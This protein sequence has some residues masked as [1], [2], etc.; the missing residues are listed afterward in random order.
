MAAF[1]I[2][3]PATRSCPL[4]FLSGN[5]WDSPEKFTVELQN[6][7]QKPIRRLI[8][9]S[10]YFLGPQYLHRP[11]TD[12]NWS[13]SQPL[14]PGQQQVLEKKAY[15]TPTSKQILGWVLFPSIINYEDGT[16]WKPE[17][18]GE[19]F[20]IFWRDREHPNLTVLPPLQVDLNED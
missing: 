3:Q 5:F 2:Y 15:A 17:Q 7:S 12:A 14:Q 11:F 1:T 8:L 20:Q 13:S 18:D 19:C 10:E 4:K 9:T 16:T 6:S